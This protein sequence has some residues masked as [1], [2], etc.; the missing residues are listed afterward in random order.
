VTHF[1]LHV[2]KRVVGVGHWLED[3]R[4]YLANLKPPSPDYDFADMSTGAMRAATA[5]R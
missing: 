2:S 3:L 4:P 1:S 5:T